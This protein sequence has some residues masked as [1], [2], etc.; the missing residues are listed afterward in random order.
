MSYS[1]LSLVAAV[2]VFA[3]YKLLSSTDKPKIAGIPEIPGVPVFGNLLQLG[4]EHAKVAAGWA[5]KYGPV[6]QARLGNKVR[7]VKPADLSTGM[8]LTKEF[9]ASSSSTPSTQSATSGSPTNPPSSPARRSTRSTMSFL[10]LKASQSERLP[11]MSPASSVARPRLQLSTVPLCSPTCP[12]SISNPTP[13]S[14]SS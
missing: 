13:L 3:L 10:H 4:E 5:K 14:R 1:T 7:L 9:S 12:S 2:V 6:F 11:G 8:I